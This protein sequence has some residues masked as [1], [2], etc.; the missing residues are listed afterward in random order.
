MCCAICLQCRTECALLLAIFCAGKAK[1]SIVIFLSYF[2]VWLLLTE[3]LLNI[4]KYCLTQQKSWNFSV[5]FHIN[6]VLIYIYKPINQ[7]EALN[8]L[9]PKMKLVFVQ[10]W[11]T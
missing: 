9:Y 8:E 6:N 10:D 1:L 2:M 7:N 11:I 5:H 3:A 4:T